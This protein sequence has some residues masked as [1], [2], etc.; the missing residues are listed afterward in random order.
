LPSTISIASLGQ[1]STHAPQPVQV[2]L[3]TIAGIYISFQIKISRIASQT[4][5]GVYIISEAKTILFFGIFQKNNG[6]KR[7][8]YN[9][10]GGFCKIL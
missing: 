7:A 8:F 5:L 6:V 9:R 10:N 3:S 1:Q 2:P 4:G